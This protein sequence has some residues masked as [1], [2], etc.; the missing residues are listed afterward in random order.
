[1]KHSAFRKTVALLIGML[2]VFHCCFAAF[3]EEP[4]PANE[5]EEE[6]TYDLFSDEVTVHRLWGLFTAW[7]VD[8]PEWMTMNDEP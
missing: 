7:A 5:P 8:D 2:L 3:A 6:V 1:M 4:A